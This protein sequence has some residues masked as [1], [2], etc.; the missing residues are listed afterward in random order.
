MAQWVKIPSTQDL[1]LFD[2]PNPCK[3]RRALNSTELSPDFHTNTGILVRTDR[4]HTD[5][6]IQRE[7]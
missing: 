5:N 7:I 6:K 3:G 4:V 1:D 2:S